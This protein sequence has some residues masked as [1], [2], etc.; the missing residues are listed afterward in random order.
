M[1]N[2]GVC[3]RPHGKDRNGKI[4]LRYLYSVENKNACEPVMI[5]LFKNLF[6]KKT[7][8]CQVKK[9]VLEKA[10]NFC[11]NLSNNK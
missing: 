9:S 5:S 10:V 8:P 3:S 2:K 4:G 1:Y 6:A 7:W 11:T